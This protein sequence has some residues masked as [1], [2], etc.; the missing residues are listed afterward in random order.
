VKIYRYMGYTG[1]Q[2]S[3]DRTDLDNYCIFGVIEANNVT[4]YGERRGIFGPLLIRIYPSV[5][6]LHMG[7]LIC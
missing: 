1:I 3:L 5:P 7:Q 4:V 6:A 2:G